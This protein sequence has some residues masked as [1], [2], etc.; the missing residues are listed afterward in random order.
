MM[1]LTQLSKPSEA[2]IYVCCIG[3]S[4]GC[5]TSSLVQRFCKPNEMLPVH[6]ETTQQTYGAKLYKKKF[7]LGPQDLRFRVWDVPGVMRSKGDAVALCV[8]V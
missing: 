1:E 8:I 3:G 6:D 4:P 5:G 7:S 2:P